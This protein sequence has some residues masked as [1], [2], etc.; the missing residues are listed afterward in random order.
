MRKKGGGVINVCQLGVRLVTLLRRDP[1]GQVRYRM[2]TTGW[3]LAQDCMGT[4]IMSRDG[5]LSDEDLRILVELENDPKVRFLMAWGD[6]G[7]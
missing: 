6:D 2:D 4:D 3:V 5:P 7:R 1:Q